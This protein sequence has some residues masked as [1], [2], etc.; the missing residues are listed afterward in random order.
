MGKQICDLLKRKGVKYHEVRSETGKISPESWKSLKVWEG[1]INQDCRDAVMLILWMRNKIILIKLIYYVLLQGE[2]IN[3][4]DWVSDIFKKKVVAAITSN[5]DNQ[6][7]NQPHRVKPDMA[8]LTLSVHLAFNA[9]WT[10]EGKITTVGV[11]NTFTISGNVPC[12]HSTVLA[13]PGAALLSIFFHFK[14]I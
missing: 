9:A 4:K 1:R 3:R 13:P 10:G 8:F 6:R 5:N 7:T 12:N 2:Y 14:R 11:P